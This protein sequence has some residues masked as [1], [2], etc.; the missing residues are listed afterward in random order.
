MKNQ[1][2]YHEIASSTAHRKVREDI[3]CHV[4]KHPEDFELLLSIALDLKDKHHYKACWI[5]ELVLEAKLDLL[6]EKLDNFC[7]ALPLYKQDGAVR[8]VSK[9]CLFLTRK[10]LL[11]FR[12]NKPFLTVSQFSKITDSCIDW[13]ISETKVASKV[14]AMRAIFA[15]GQIENQLHTAL[16]EVVEKDFAQHSPAYKLAAKDILK[17]MKSV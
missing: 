14:Y 17:Q 6:D 4:L 12:K 5:L 9:T 8:S 3:A 7:D 13:L 15:A 10:H 2:L 11:Q 1:A 16:L